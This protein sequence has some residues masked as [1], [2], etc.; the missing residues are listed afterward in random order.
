M[1]HPLFVKTQFEHSLELEDI[2]RSS[3]RTATDY[4]VTTT[5][6]KTSCDIE[7]ARGIAIPLILGGGVSRTTV[8][9]LTSVPFIRA[10]GAISLSKQ[11]KGRGE[12][13]YIMSNVFHDEDATLPYDAADGE[14]SGLT[15]KVNAIMK[16]NATKN[17][18]LDL[19]VYWERNSIEARSWVRGNMELRAYF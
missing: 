4:N 16:Y 19:S 3:G 6:A 1:K 10:E 14:K 9:G 7:V 11:E 18:D 15:H 17:I 5:R 8:L 12:L 2:D 13:R